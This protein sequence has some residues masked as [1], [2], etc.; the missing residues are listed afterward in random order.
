[1]SKV[2]RIAAAL[3]DDEGG[4]V[5]LVR[6]RGTAAFMQAGGKLDVGETAFEALVRELTE[7][8]HFTPTE[9][10]SRFVGT[11]S[12]EAANEPDHLLQAHLFHIRA[13]NRKFAVAA[14][15]EEAIWVSTDGCD[16]SAPRSICARSRAATGT[17]NARVSSRLRQRSMH[18][19][20]RQ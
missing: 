10:E 14:E 17:L 3:I 8:L 16:Q 12:C 6:K 4:R 13:N 18:W 2:I 19:R 15:L 11:F 9:E 7:E 1:M 20:S 5:F